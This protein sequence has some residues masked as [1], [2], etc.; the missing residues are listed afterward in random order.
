LFLPLLFLKDYSAAKGKYLKYKYQNYTVA[1][2]SEHK[3]K[4]GIIQIFFKIQTQFI[5]I[6]QNLKNIKILLSLLMK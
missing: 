5:V 2:Q 6:F 3:R 4:I 1:Y